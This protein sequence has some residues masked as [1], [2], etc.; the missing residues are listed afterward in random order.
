[1]LFEPEHIFGIF[2]V[3]KNWPVLNIFK[4]LV[5]VVQMLK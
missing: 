1:M 2:K 5:S 4:Y 3:K